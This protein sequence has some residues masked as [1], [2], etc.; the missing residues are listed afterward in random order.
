MI[1]PVDS[2]IQL[3]NN[4]GLET[5]Q[6]FDVNSSKKKCLLYWMVY[7]H[8]RLVT[9]L[10]TKNR[11]FQEPWSLIKQKGRNTLGD[12]LQQHAMETDHSLCAAGRATSHSCNT[13]RPQHTCVEEIFWWKFVSATIFCRCNKSHKFCLIWCFCDMLRRQ[14]FSQKSSTTQEAICRCDESPRHVIANWRLVCTD[15]NWRLR[16]LSTLI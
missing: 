12:E 7:Q 15:L 6:Y 10:Q 1:Y 3:S 9:R 2:A 8:G 16:W 5:K 4:W 14:R 11:K 13:L